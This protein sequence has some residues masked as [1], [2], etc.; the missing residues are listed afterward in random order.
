[1]AAEDKSGGRTLPKCRTDQ[2]GRSIILVEA[3]EARGEIHRGAKRSI[4]HA[5][6]RADIADDS[7]SG[8]EAASGFVGRP[9]F[10][11]E[12]GIQAIVGALKGERGGAGVDGMIGIVGRGAPYS[13]T[14]LPD[15]P[16]CW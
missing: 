11:L 5:I 3:F 12:L 14:R 16:F 6:D 1:D 10:A 4:V 8:M 2:D 15:E 13:H 7:L 9:S